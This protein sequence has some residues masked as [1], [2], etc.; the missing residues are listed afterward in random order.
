MDSNSSNRH[1]WTW[2]LP[3]M[4]WRWYLCWICFQRTRIAESRWIKAINS[5]RFWMLWFD[6]F[7]RHFVLREQWKKRSIK[8]QRQRE[9]WPVDPTLSWRI[10]IYIGK[11]TG[12][13][14]CRWQWIRNFW[15][16]VLM[17]SKILIPKKSNCDVFCCPSGRLIDICL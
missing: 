11:F 9:A 16:G 14:D 5:G 12:S 13:I 2:L 3:Q 1:S 10:D 17:H 8:I 7:Q 4:Y 6:S 15:Q